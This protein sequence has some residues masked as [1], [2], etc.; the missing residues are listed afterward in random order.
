MSLFNSIELRELTERC[1]VH[2]HLPEQIDADPDHDDEGED[3]IQGL[4]NLLI[5]VR[6]DGAPEYTFTTTRRFTIRLEDGETSV[7]LYADSEWPWDAHHELL[8]IQSE[9]LQAILDQ[10]PQKL[11]PSQTIINHLSALPFFSSVEQTTKEVDQD[12]PLCPNCG[13]RLDLESAVRREYVNKDG[14]SQD[15]SVFALGHYKHD[16]F[17]SDEFPGFPNSRFDLLDDSDTC[18]HCEHQL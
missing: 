11:Y 8:P 9:L 6:F 18:A 1:T 7:K 4:D 15:D 17:L 5:E 16:E 12:A 3:A 14:E 13:S 10:E 2:W